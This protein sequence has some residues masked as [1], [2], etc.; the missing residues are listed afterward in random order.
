MSIA[1]NFERLNIERLSKTGNQTPIER[2]H[3]R[4]YNSSG[5]SKDIAV[6]QDQTIC[7]T[8]PFCSIYFTL[9]V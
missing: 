2:F 9:I 3:S 6:Y 1:N 7:F 8:E 5:I 4:I